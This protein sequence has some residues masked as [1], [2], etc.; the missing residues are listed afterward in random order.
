M[1]KEKTTTK[2]RPH[3]TTFMMVAASE[4]KGIVGDILGPQVGFQVV[5]DGFTQKNCRKIL[6][7]YMPILFQQFLGPTD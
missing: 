4:F 6:Y 3:F 5:P 7:L 2:T 1:S